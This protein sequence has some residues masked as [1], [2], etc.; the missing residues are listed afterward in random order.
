MRRLRLLLWAAVALAA[1]G[2]GLLALRAGED[3][4]RSTSRPDPDAVLSIGGDFTLVD[5]AGEPFESRQ[6][7][8]RPH[9]VFFG[10]THCPDVCPTTLAQLVRLREALGGEEAFEILFISVDPERDGPE[11]VGRYAELFGTDVIGL[12]GSRAQIETVM[13]QFGVAAI[14]APGEGGSYQVD[15]TAN[16]FLIDADG[17][18]QSTISP[19]ESAAAARAKL[20]RLIG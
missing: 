1:I 4:P 7:A 16:V 11:E 3:A 18:F 14:R 19:E 13:E 5:A 10:F 12:T 8:G 6:L 20:E 2:Y 15:H 9:A 17:A